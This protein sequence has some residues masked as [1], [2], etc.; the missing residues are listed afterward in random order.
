MSNEAIIIDNVSVK[1]NLAKEKV[2]NAKEYALKMLKKQLKFN[3]FY[4]LQN[5]SFSIQKGDSFAIIGENGCG[6]STLLKVISGI[7]SPAAGKVKTEGTISPLIELGAGFDMDLTARENIYLNGAVLGYSKAFMQDHF[8]EIIDFAELHEFIDVPLKN[9]SSGMIARLGFAI[10]TVTT[11]DILIVDEILAVGD[12]NFQKKC[13]Q[14][15]SEMLNGGTTL[16]FVSHDIN[17]VKKL[18]KHAVWLNKGVVQMV[19]DTETV[20]DAYVK[21]M[22]E[23]GGRG[24]VHAKDISQASDEEFASKDAESVSIDAADKKYGFISWISLFALLLFIGNTFCDIFGNLNIQSRITLFIKNHIVS[25]FGIDLGYL[26]AVMILISVGFINAERIAHESTSRYWKKNLKAI[27]IPL[28][29]SVFTLWLVQLAVSAISGEPT[30]WSQFT[31]WEWLQSASLIGHFTGISDKIIGVTWILI[32]II[33]YFIFCSAFR[34]LTAEHK[35]AF[36][37]SGLIFVSLFSFAFSYLGGAWF[38]FANYI[39]HIPLLLLGHVI[40]AIYTKA[41]ELKSAV[42]FLVID[43]V[44]L[45]QSIRLFSPENYYG[46]SPKAPSLIIGALIFCIALTASAKVK[47]IPQISRADKVFCILY[48]INYPLAQLII[49]LLVSMS[50]MSAT[51]VIM[52]CIA[53]ITLIAIFEIIVIT[54]PSRF[55]NFIKR[56][57]HR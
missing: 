10:A 23:N 13:E 5:V 3:E 34:F 17:Q 51:M 19:G 55:F 32:P 8:G 47:S 31:L 36:I 1:F 38:T 12:M 9:Y 44:I 20:A 50:T 26:G 15:M 48:L 43:I 39:Q 25:P 21:D 53:I 18:C 4:A 35:K 2:D 40:F 27:F 57:L 30:Y 29:I 6:K 37:I 49:P 56:R 28:I 41:T 7:Y 54:L 22:Q 42:I 24:I 46:N 45:M 16:L 33:I 14:K 52:L 11:P